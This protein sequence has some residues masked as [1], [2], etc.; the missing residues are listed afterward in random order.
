MRERLEGCRVRLD[1]YELLNRHVVQIRFFKRGGGGKRYDAFD[2]HVGKKATADIG[3][4][5]CL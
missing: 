3:S 1:I 2:W 5:K 4:V